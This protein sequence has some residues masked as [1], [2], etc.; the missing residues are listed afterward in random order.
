MRYRLKSRSAAYC[1]TLLLAMLPSHYAAACKWVPG[2]YEMNTS[3]TVNVVDRTKP[4]VGVKVVLG[5]GGSG[6]RE[7]RYSVLTDDKGEAHFSELAPGTYLLDFSG[8]LAKPYWDE[9][10]V[11]PS[12]PA[13]EKITIEWPGGVIAVRNVRGRLTGTEDLDFDP[14]P[15]QYTELTLRDVYTS[16]E[17]ARSKTDSDGYYDFGDTLPGV[18]LLTAYG[19]TRNRKIFGGYSEETVAVVQMDPSAAEEE[20]LTRVLTRLGCGVGA[21]PPKVLDKMKRSR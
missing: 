21:L 5:V 18:Y 10:E 15:L 3:F 9:V 6:I 1:A 14:I 13:N 8:V 20:L 4:V 11:S 7:I 17:V 2:H 16:R 12:N 19:D